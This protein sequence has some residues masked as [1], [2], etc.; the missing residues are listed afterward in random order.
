MKQ[1]KKR[2][3]KTFQFWFN[4]LLGTELMD[5]PQHRKEYLRALLVFKK[6]S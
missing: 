4:V 5:D 2:A 6:K 3:K 1:Q